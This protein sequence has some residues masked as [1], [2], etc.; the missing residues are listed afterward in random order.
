MDNS[1]DP[2]RDNTPVQSHDESLGTHDM[3]VPGGS[4]SDQGPVTCD[5]ALE[6]T[7]ATSRSNLPITA[8]NNAI[9]AG[10]T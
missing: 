8:E 10:D 2:T 9:S 4:D 3:P 6:T 5:M 1:V 7:G